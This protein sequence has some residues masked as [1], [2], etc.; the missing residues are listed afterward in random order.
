MQDTGTTI[1]RPA[2]TPV[3]F[4]AIAGPDVGDLFDP[5]R[6][7]AIH[8]W[9]VEQGAEWENVGQWKRPWYFPRSG[10][11]MQ[12]AVNRECLAVR[13]QVGILDASTLGKID[14]QGPDAAEFL[15]R[16]YTNS[17]LKLAPGK[18]RYGLMLK[19]DGYHLVRDL[20]VM[21]EA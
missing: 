2:Y 19:E 8:R 1:F 15:T 7:T 18:C 10:E 14:I 3:T 21:R 11:S 6:Y 17:F 9:H 5:V 16:I 20:I 13:N 12:E 4:G